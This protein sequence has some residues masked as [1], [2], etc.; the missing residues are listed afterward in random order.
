MTETND[1]RLPVGIQFFEEDTLQAYL[2]GKKELFEGLK[3]MDLEKGSWTGRLWNK[4][5]RQNRKKKKVD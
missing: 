2:E 1:R 4:G 3:I 5:F